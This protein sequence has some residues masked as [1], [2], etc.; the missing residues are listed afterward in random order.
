MSHGTNVPQTWQFMATGLILAWGL[1]PSGGWQGAVVEQARVSMRSDLLNRA[2]YERME[3]GYY[4]QLLDAGRTLGTSQ[5]TQAPPTNGPAG[6]SLVCD[7]VNDLR[8]M[9]P[10][11]NLVYR[12][13]VGASWS[14]NEQGMRDRFYSLAKPPRTLRIGM[15]GDSIGAGWG[16]GDNLGFEP[17]LEQTLDRSAKR[18][19]GARV[20]ILNFALPGRCPGQRWYHLNEVGGWSM[21]LD[22]VLVEA[23]Q[24]DVGWAGRRLRELLPRG[25][26]WDSPLYAEVLASCGLT[27]GQP[28]EVYE[29]A[30][31]PHAW[32][33]VLREYQAIV[34]GCSARNVPSIWVLL[35]RVGRPVKAEEHQRLVSVAQAAGFSAIVD[36]SDAFDGHN[37]ATLTAR[38][39]D[40]HPNAKG[41]AILADRIEQALQNHPLLIDLQS[42]AQE[43]AAGELSESAS[44]A[45]M[46]PASSS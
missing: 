22:L 14:T 4:E 16:V 5:V 31:R 25:I 35:P 11:P 40:Y 26:G 18:D 9:V 15:M 38:H 37:P 27:P 33:L 24:A 46:D 29:R 17:L 8:E 23:T 44:E 36:V 10:R 39:D 20:E 32:E 7:V 6:P 45:A 1:M 30:L 19:R 43:E 2:D 28:G 41:H 13:P 42:R 3:R 21:G 34:Q 12:Q